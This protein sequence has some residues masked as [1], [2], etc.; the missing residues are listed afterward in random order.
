MRSLNPVG[1]WPLEETDK[2]LVDLS[3]ANNHAQI[4]NTPWSGGLLDFSS[5]YQY[6][7]IPGPANYFHQAF[8][9]GL[10]VYSR[11]TSY[12]RDGVALIGSWPRQPL[13]V[14][15]RLSGKDK[16]AVEVISNNQKDAL[17]SVEAGITVDANAWQHVV[18]SFKDGQGKLY[19][20]GKLVH[21]KDAV[22]YRPAA[23]GHAVLAGYD[24]DWWGVHPVG[25]QSLDGSLRHLIFFN[26]AL[27]D[28]EVKD[29]ASATKPRVNPHQQAADEIRVKGRFIKLSD[30]G[31][32]PLEVQRQALYLM[33]NDKWDGDLDQN[34]ELLRDYLAV[35]LDSA[36]L[37]YD[38]VL[39]LKKMG[40]L[41]QLESAAPRL[42]ELAADGGAARVER[43]SAALALGAMGQPALT[44]VETLQA[45]LEADLESTGAHIPRVEAIVR[46]AL[47]YALLRIAPEQPTVNQLLGRAYAKPLLEVLDVAALE[48]PELSDLVGRGQWMK[49]LEVAKDLFKKHQ[50]YFLTQ[51]D[52]YRD[53]RAGIHERSYTSA[54]M[55][56]GIT[57]Q[58][59]SGKSYAGCEPI[60]P[61][62]YKQ[63]LA[64]YA[65]KYPASN[66]WL[67]GDVSQMRRARL[68]A[69]SP[70]QPD[71]AAFIG[72]PDFLFS[73]R[74][75][76]VCCWAVAIDQDGYLHVM[77]G[78]HN[79]P[80]YADYMPGAWQEIGL[81]ANK[82]SAQYPTTLYW[83][84]KRPLEIDAFNFVGFKDHP[85]AVPAT[86]LNYM[87][88]VQDHQGKLYLYGRVDGWG[89]Q[90]WG[91]FEYDTGKR[92][93]T[94]I[95]GLAGGVIKSARANNSEWMGYLQRQYR[96]LIPHDNG[97]RLL[98]WA[99][100]PHFYN[101]NRS[102]KGVRFDPE[103]RMIVQIGVRGLDVDGRYA[104]HQLFAYSDD[105]GK[106]FH[107]ADG[108]LVALPLTANPAP[109]HNAKVSLGLNRLWIMQWTALLTWA[110][111]GP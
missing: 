3:P 18:Y 76:K 13:P 55:H 7:H 62:D 57:Y 63:A 93:W 75:G 51:N 84:S 78:Q 92:R 6:L 31:E 1:Y 23:K 74:D 22:P 12:L 105:G 58:F 60:T 11:R 97:P 77:G 81:S 106:T 50:V 86:Y 30:L 4:F 111:L 47:I 64:R 43:A 25:S 98:A 79:Q 85:R 40:E 80:R 33:H 28:A 56:K 108:S 100:Q 17:G 2:V 89:I 72:G 110:G 37:R 9:I 35:A 34:A 107:R 21:T 96:G 46:N 73:A 27:T 59:G 83:V 91:L 45:T 67:D 102:K 88:F 94:P 103:N 69:I 20:N 104:S 71:R 90:S 65:E 26:R 32:E 8:T 68:R 109:A 61:T 52:P 44:Q 87:N 38:A 14:S 49:A 66:K 5:S 99:W 70:S 19:I 82:M 54:A 53:A 10:W 95:G 101:Y 29:L 48:R 16:L 42:A 15:L 41:Q 39:V 24:A 36:A